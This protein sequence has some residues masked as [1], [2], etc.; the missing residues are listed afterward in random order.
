MWRI[1]SL[2][3]EGVV[4]QTSV[5]QFSSLKGIKLAALGIVSYCEDV[6]QAVD[7]AEK[8]KTYERFSE[9][10]VK[11]KAFE[12]EREVRLV[13]AA[14][15]QCL[16][17]KPPSGCLWFNIDC[18]P[19]C[20]IEGIKIDPRADD[21]YVNDLQNYCKRSGLVC[22]PTKS[23]LYGDLYEHTGLVTTYRTAKS[24]RKSKA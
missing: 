15:S 23:T 6:K 2:Q 13:T 3:K 8:E 24:A 9:A 19:T 14:D 21:H 17:L 22:R 20:F 16:A 11:R 18:D 12:H 5:K 7:K 1:Y 4:I 10:F